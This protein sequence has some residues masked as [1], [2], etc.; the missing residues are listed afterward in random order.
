MRWRITLGVLAVLLGRVRVG[1][2]GPD[3][4]R[5]GTDRRAAGVQRDRRAVIATV[6]F[7]ERFGRWRIAATVLVADGVVLVTV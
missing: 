3:P 5:A 2:L 4:G 7:G 1:A 6:L